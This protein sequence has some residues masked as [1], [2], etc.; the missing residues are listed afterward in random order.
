MAVTTHYYGRSGEVQRDKTVFGFLN[1]LE[2]IVYVV[3]LLFFSGAIIALLFTDL[4]NLDQ[5]NPL[6]RL[7][8]FP[9]YGVVLALILR[10]FPGFFRMSIFSPIIVLCVMWCGISMFWSVDFGVT[11]RRSVALLITTMAGLVLAARF[12]WSEMV[13]KIAFTFAILAIITVL[14]ALL[15]PSRGVMSEIHVGAW[16]GPWVEKNYL[17]G[18]MTKGLIAV[19]CAFAMRP[20]RWWLWFPTGL[21]CFALV[22]MST[23]KTAL[24]ISVTAIAFFIALRIFRRFPI[25]RV[26]LVYAVI[27]SITGF[28][29]AML[30]APEFMFS[31]IGK[32]PTFTGRTDI[33][34][35]ISTSIRNEWLLGYGYGAYWLDPL[36]PSYY[37]RLALEWGVPSAHNGWM[38]LWLAGGVIAVV[39]FAI[40]LLIIVGLSIDRVFRGGTE[41]YWVVLSTMMFI[42]FSLSESSI[43]MQNDISWVMFVATSA[44]LMSFEKPFWRRPEDHPQSYLNV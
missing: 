30:I 24:L 10:T 19:M 2:N 8:W 41:T 17:G 39:I 4:S 18:M 7:A 1:F 29:A 35:L 44:K 28:A 26:P 36:G 13:Q 11:M 33:W 23:S 27:A 20:D 37:V 22:L 12:T 42:G 43:L 14:V 16:R 15:N 21:L 38:D 34:A 3:L 5:E 32:D 9:V 31:L 6:A 25:L 40:H